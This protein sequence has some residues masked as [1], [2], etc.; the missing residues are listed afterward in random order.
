MYAAT[1]EVQND[2][3]HRWTELDNKRSSVLHNCEEYASWTLPYVFPPIGANNQNVELQASKDSIGAQAVNHLANKVVSTLFP[4]QRLFFRLKVDAKTTK[5]IKAALSA[6]AQGDTAQAQAELQRALDAADTELL[7]VEKE[8]N[9]YLDMVAYRPVAVNAAK[10]LI[11]TGNALMFHPKD[12]PV[13]CYSLRDY[14]VVRDISGQVIEIMTRESK[15]FETF[16]PNIQEQLRA[17]K[18]SMH[19][20]ARQYAEKDNVTIYTQIRLEDDGKFHVRQCGDHIK[21]NTDGAVWTRDTLPWIPL[22]WD[23]VQ[24]EDYGR[25]RVAEYSGAF[26]AVNVLTGS[27]LN[28]AAIM[29]DTKFL[30]NPASV[31]DIPTLNASLP[32]SYHSGKEGDITTPQLNKISDAQFIQ[33]MIDRYERQLAQAFLLN[34]QLTRNAE[35]VTAEEIRR[36]ADELE[37]SN[38]GIYSRLAAGWQ[39]PTAIIVLKHIDFVGIGDGIVPQIITGMDSLS[40]ASEMDNL[41]MFLID[42]AALNGVPEDVRAYIDKPAY[43][44]VCGKNRQVEYNAFT[45]TNAEVQAEQQ[46]L[47]Q[48]AMQMEAQ[49][50][51]GA[52]AAEAGKQAIKES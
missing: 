36:D 30:V 35:R 31:L 6:E 37:L 17:L 43:M 5:I 20:H 1:V 9:E 29:G 24:G 26:H 21:L 16:A 48:A 14:C 7:A 2:L 34:S 49:K 33:A 28:M 25:G 13:Q 8:A 3:A 38:G 42:L 4:G 40:R 51:Q 19:K 52:V 10:L 44:A 15:A 45:R 32:G 39:Q 50:Q 22:T 27:L 18:P 46:A 23:L 12:K 11:I 41:R 47:Q